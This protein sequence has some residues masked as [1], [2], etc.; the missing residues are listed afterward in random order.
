M[1]PLDG[2]KYEMTESYKGSDYTV[3]IVASLAIV[4]QLVH[5]TWYVLLICPILHMAMGRIS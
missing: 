1:G 2:T 5:C 4:I 3:I